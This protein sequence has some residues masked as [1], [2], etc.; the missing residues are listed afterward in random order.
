MYDGWIA[1]NP[2]RINVGSIGIKH[3]KHQYE[4]ISPAY[5]VFSCTSDL[6]PEYLFLLMKTP[7]FNKIIRE[8][9]TGSVRQNLSFKTLQKLRLPLPE[10]SVQNKFVAK[11]N[12]TIAEAKTKEDQARQLENE[13]DQGLLIELGASVSKSSFSNR[14]NFI[15]FVDTKRWDVSYFE[16]STKVMSRYPTTS[17]GNCVDH[18]MENSDGQTIRVETS[19]TPNANYHYLGME[20]VEKNTGELIEL[21][22][23]NGGDVKSQTLQ[24]PANYF[25]Y[26]KLRPYLNK[27]W[28]NDTQLSDIV[29]SSEFLVF[30]VKPNI[31]TLY[32][33]Y[34]LSSSFVQQQLADLSS[35]ARMPRI[36]EN[37]FK[38]IQIP[39]PPINIQNE[40]AK[41]ISNKKERIKHLKQQASDLRKKALADF[42]NEIFE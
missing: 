6:L 19:R 7:S 34:V 36:N 15:R 23:I 5:V 29:C 11:Y 18:F 2:Y 37:I 3:R 25:I 32:F 20:S 39:I 24:V 9:T 41:L 35:G 38:N 16:S 10:T 31:N 14:L 40:I 26:G 21:P 8:N 33:K 12:Q 13:I 27:Y 1:Y 28:F 42:E 17:I 30:H 22:V 4:Y